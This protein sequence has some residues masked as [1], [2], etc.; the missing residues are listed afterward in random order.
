[1][2]IVDRLAALSNIVMLHLSSPSL[3]SSAE[4]YLADPVYPN[5][6]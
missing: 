3:I 4:D 5:E 2:L 1:M 6:E